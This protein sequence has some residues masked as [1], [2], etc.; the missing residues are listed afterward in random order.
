MKKS[1][2]IFAAAAVLIALF[3]P[4]PMAGANAVALFEVLPPADMVPIVVM[5]GGKFVDPYAEGDRFLAAYYKPGKRFKLFMA[6]EPAGWAAFQSWSVE[7]CGALD[8]AVSLKHARPISAGAPPALA[9]SGGA[10]L[11]GYAAASKA[12]TPAERNAL[13]RLARSILAR[14]GVAPAGLAKLTPGQVFALAGGGEL[15]GSFDIPNDDPGKVLTIFLISGLQNGK[16]AT[17]LEWDDHNQPAG[18]HSTKEAV[19]AVNLDRSETPEIITIDVS[20]DASS[21]TIY[22]KLNGAWRAVYHGGGADC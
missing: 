8:C 3:S 20:G 22:K 5:D 17:E 10:N 18:K 12:A 7:G 11:A 13:A 4:R 16:Q 6:G 2:G 15:A 19:F 9:V 1:I 21:Y 14:E